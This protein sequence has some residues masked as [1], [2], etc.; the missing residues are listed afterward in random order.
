[1]ILK[2]G[3]SLYHG[4]YAKIENINLEK[5]L[6]GKDFGTGFYLTSDYAQAAKFIKTSIAKAVKNR[7][8]DESV[9][10]GYVT[11]FIFNK[12]CQRCN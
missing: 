4:S 1:M 12:N 9:N 7:L 5:C 11:K 3:I 8:I 6:D 10:T 2:N